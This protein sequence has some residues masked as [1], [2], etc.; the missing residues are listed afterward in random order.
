MAKYGEPV[1]RQT[2]AYGIAYAQPRPQPASWDA[3]GPRVW[4]VRG[5][6]LKVEVCL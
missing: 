3:N 6:H 4:R 2:I 5:G 1:A